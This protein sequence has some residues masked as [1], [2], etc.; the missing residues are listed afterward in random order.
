MGFLP[1][2]QTPSAPKNICGHPSLDFPCWRHESGR[3]KK[4]LPFSYELLLLVI[5]LVAWATRVWIYEI[6]RK[7]AEFAAGEWQTPQCLDSLLYPPNHGLLTP[8]QLPQC[9]LRNASPRQQAASEYGKDSFPTDELF[10]PAFI[11]WRG[12]GVPVTYLRAPEP[13]VE[14]AQRQTSSGVQIG[15]DGYQAAWSMS[16][17]RGST[18]AW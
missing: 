17:C 8:T 10:P 18:L 7:A 4:F 11:H 6:G 16:F 15:V 2:W 12:G 9:F 3:Q 5:T 13:S 1:P 14:T